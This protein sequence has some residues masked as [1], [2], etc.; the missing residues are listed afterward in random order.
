[1]AETIFFGLFSLDPIPFANVS[2]LIQHPHAD[3][4]LQPVNEKIINQ[5]WVVS[6]RFQDSFPIADPRLPL[7]E[8]RK[9]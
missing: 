2:E 1:M 9:A 3:T 6:C 5:L 7:P 8:N 4:G